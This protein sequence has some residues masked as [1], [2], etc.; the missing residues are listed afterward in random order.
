MSEQQAMI[1]LAQQLNAHAEMIARIEGMRAENFKR[2]RNGDALA[3]TE[4]EFFDLTNQL[5]CH[6]NERCEIMQRCSW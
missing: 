5:G 1:E 4:Q 2:D 6:H 3:Y